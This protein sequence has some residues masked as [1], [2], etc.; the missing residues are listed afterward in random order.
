[1]PQVRIDQANFC[2]LKSLTLYHLSYLNFIAKLI[3]SLDS[4]GLRKK[5]SKNY[6]KK[7][8]DIKAT[9]FFAEN[10]KLKELKER[11]KLE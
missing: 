1:M 11:L 4:I 2:W 6:R 3:F 9:N 5:K 8:K 7:S 10:N